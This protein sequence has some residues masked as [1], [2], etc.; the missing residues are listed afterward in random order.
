MLFLKLRLLCLVA[1]E[2]ESGVVQLMVEQVCI[3]MA[4]HCREA[5]VV[6]WAAKALA[7]ASPNGEIHVLGGPPNGITPEGNCTEILYENGHG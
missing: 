3:A 4:T 1:V 6:L 5:Q 2:M 7:S